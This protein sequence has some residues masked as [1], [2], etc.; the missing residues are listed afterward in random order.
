V[1][2]RTRLNDQAGRVVNL[3]P[4]LA[5]GGEGAVYTLADDPAR[6]AKV[7]HEPPD[8]AKVRKLRWMAAHADP[9]LCKF[10][11]WP[12]GTLHDTPGGPLVGFL[13]P[14]FD[15]R[16]PAHMLYSPAHRRKDFPQA[17]WA[18][19]HHVAA[20][21]AAAFGA[22]HDKG[23]VL[24]D[25]NQ[26]NALVS[27][28][29]GLVAL[30]DCDSYQV[31][32]GKTVFLC[33]VGVG[34]Y[35]PPELQGVSFREVERTANHDRFGLAVLIFHL[36]FMGR[37]PFAG[38]F[39]GTG[40]MPLEK[41]IQEYRFVYSEAD[42]STRMAPPPHSLPLRAVGKEMM[43]LFERAFGRGSEK[44][45][46]RPTAQ[47][48]HAALTAARASLR[49]CPKEAGHKV[50]GH[51]VDCPWCTIILTGGPNFFLGVG[52]PSSTF[53]PDREAFARLLA[54]VDTAAQKKH[55]LPN[56]S[57]PPGTQVSPTRPTLL[58]ALDGWV[59]R[60]PE[61][62]LALALLVLIVAMLGLRWLW[63]ADYPE[64]GEDAGWWWGLTGWARWI[65][66]YTSAS[67]GLALLA[68]FVPLMVYGML[69]DVYGPEKKRRLE[70]LKAALHN[71]NAARAEWPAVVARYAAEHGRILGVVKPLRDA[72]DALEAEFQKERR[73][74]ARRHPQSDWARQETEREAHARRERERESRAREE[75]LRSHF[76]NDRKTKV[77]GIGPGRVVLLAS[78]GVETA[79][80]ITPEALEPIRG[81]GQ[82][83][84][85]NLLAWREE[86]MAAFRFDAGRVPP[87][88]KCEP[89]AS[90]EIQAL[91]LRYKQREE[92]ARSQLQKSAIELEALDRQTE[93]DLQ[94]V[95]GRITAAF[96]AH[97]RAE[98]DTEA[99]P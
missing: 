29:D 64:V 86:V 85:Q 22:V 93:E 77:P 21:C 43:A 47:E 78:Y 98:A 8:A 25:V 17:D 81:I 74:L 6:L 62:Y 41:A 26:S 20:N 59:R 2:P 24:G 38:R 11:A 33:E 10:A 55:P 67:V 82:K 90:P 12:T 75:H 1:K 65:G 60:L 88:P 14:R 48:W 31:R 16:L 18:F 58:M 30:I 35:T 56:L 49:P 66:S 57:V 70:E 76:L 69:P 84:Q 79:F 37:H 9:G 73:E 23:H 39:L 52:P 63:V 83:L 91:V 89:A 51:L 32:D 7:H 94:T 54:R 27:P 68:W 45:W 3:G 13:M 15:G 72:P 4:V 46:A 53:S 96:V 36:L 92:A 61:R 40:D 42:P 87:E 71:M 28:A 34:P 44:D 19:L 99:L 80:D 95:L 97:A 50:P 5:S